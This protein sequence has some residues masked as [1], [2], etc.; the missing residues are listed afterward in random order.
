MSEI[1]V[2]DN[3]ERSR[4]EA[5]DGDEVVGFADY[6]VDGDTITIPHTEVH[7]EGEGIGG[8]IVRAAVDAARADGKRVNPEC[9]FVRAWIEKHPEYADLVD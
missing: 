7:R 6:T 3:P 5:R 8:R 2:I 9:P 4:W 1:V